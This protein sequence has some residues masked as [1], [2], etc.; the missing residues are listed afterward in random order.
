MLERVFLLDLARLLLRIQLRVFAVKLPDTLGEILLVNT[1]DLGLAQS[2]V[3]YLLA[4]LL[5]IDAAL[6]ASVISFACSR[7]SRPTS[8]RFRASSVPTFDRFESLSYS[9]PMRLRS[10]T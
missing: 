2:V 9:W 6:L 5:G 10:S 1:G 8:R 7:A 3:K 4:L